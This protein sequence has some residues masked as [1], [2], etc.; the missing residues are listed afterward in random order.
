MSDPGI[1]TAT[2]PQAPDDDFARRLRGFGPAGIGAVMVILAGNLIFAPLSAAFAL[3]WARRAHIPWSALGFVRPRSWWRTVLIGAAFGVAFKL[4]MKS[5]VMPLLQADPINHT[6]H[7]LVRNPSA[8]LAFVPQLIVVAGFGE[9]TLFRGYLFERLG[10]LWGRG[11]IATAATVLATSLFFGSLHYH[12][13]GLAGAQ[14]ATVVG[15][16]FGSIFART[17]SIG[18]LMIAHAS[19]DLA[20]VA[21]IYWDLETTVARLFF[22]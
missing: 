22:K 4:A 5:I 14:Q 2:P 17:R 18:M 13:Q 6:Y 9:E 7:F 10:R 16:V 19:F 12:D 15:L 3:M 8:A 1:P 11:S 20:A 21:I